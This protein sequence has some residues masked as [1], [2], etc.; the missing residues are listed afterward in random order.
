MIGQP[1]YGYGQCVDLGEEQDGESANDNLA[2]ANC[3]SQAFFAIGKC[4]AQRKPH[5]I[6]MLIENSYV[7]EQMQLGFKYSRGALSEP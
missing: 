2:L 6:M 1:A 3:D 5:S 7:D 4:C